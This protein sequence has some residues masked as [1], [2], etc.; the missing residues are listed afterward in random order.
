[1]QASKV[2]ATAIGLDE[3]INFANAKVVDHLTPRMQKLYVDAVAINNECHFAFCWMKSGSILLRLLADSSPYRVRNVSPVFLI[4]SAIYVL[5]I[6]CQVIFAMSS[7]TQ[8][9][10]NKNLLR[11]LPYSGHN[12]ILCAM[13]NSTTSS[14]LIISQLKSIW[15][16]SLAFMTFFL[17][18]TLN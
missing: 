6:V 2:S 8:A 4:V 12:I 11:E 9:M 13:G 7:L 16:V 15:N 17:T 1:M 5:M 3:N 10:Q 14:R 18:L